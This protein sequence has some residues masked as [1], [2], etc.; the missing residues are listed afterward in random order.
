MVP[1]MLKIPLL[2]FQC[3]PPP[4]LTPGYPLL[5]PPGRDTPWIKE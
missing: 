1:M 3:Q 4:L 5:L 2:N